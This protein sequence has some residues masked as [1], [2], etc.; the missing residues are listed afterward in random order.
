MK[1]IFT[2]AKIN[3]LGVLVPDPQAQ[4]FLREK[5]YKIGE[6]VSCAPE[7]ARSP[8]YHRFAHQFGKLVVEN[9]EGF[10]ALNAHTAIKRLQIE[11]GVGCDEIKVKVPS[12]DDTTYRIIAALL[13]I[14]LDLVGENEKHNLMTVV[15]ALSKLIEDADNNAYTD[16]RIPKSLSFANMDETEFRETMDGIAKYVIESYWPD[17]TIDEIN[18]MAECLP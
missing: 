3:D 2:I 12:I 9:I 17:M 13:D 8:E 15:D 10:E 11:S 16:V 6:K 1:H 18:R 4:A 7:R 14:M 5:G